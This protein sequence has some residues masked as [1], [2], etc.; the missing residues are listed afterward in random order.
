MRAP[1]ARTEEPDATSPELGAVPVATRVADLAKAL[2]AAEARATAAETAKAEGTMTIATAV[3]RATAAEARATAAEARATAAEARAVSAEEKRADAIG[4]ATGCKM[5]IQYMEK[6]VANSN[7]QVATANQE[8]R[9]SFE[10]GYQRGLEAG[11]R[12]ARQAIDSR[13]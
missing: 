3:A 1:R 4:E 6:A 13:L 2:A 7:T 8:A 12:E 5:Q 9:A 10:Q 11:K